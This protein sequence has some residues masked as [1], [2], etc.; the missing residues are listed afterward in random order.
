M[1]FP[2][3]FVYTL[4][5]PFG[6]VGL[7]VPWNFPLL[8]ASWKLAQALA[9]ALRSE[10]YEVVVAPTGEEGFFHA[11]AERFDV[12]LLGLGAPPNVEIRMISRP[13]RV[14]RTRIGPRSHCIE[15]TPSLNDP[16]HMSSARM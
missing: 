2:D 12:V 15:R 10:Q 5:E 13:S 14:N 4:R 3:Q 6:V 8:T 16:I 9:S 7:I 1:S 11:H